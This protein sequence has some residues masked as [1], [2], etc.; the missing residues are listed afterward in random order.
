M[1]D[2]IGKKIKNTRIKIAKKNKDQIW[3]KKNYNQMLRDENKN[4]IQLWKW[5]KWRKK[6]QN[7]QK[8][9]I[10]FDIKI[11]LNK[12]WGIVLK[13]IKMINIKQIWFKRTS[14]KLDIKHK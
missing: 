13:D 8:M 9:R 11:K 14:D 3:H 5:R 2:E 6:L 1:R 7:W 4:K 12:W 10:K